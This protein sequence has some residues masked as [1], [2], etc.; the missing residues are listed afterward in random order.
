LFGEKTNLIEVI[1]FLVNICV[2]SAAI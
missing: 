2:S 1:Q